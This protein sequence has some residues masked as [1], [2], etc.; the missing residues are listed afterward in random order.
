MED[1]LDLQLSFISRPENLIIEWGLGM[2]FAFG[3][4]IWIGHLVEKLSLILEMIS[5]VLFGA[6]GKQSC[7]IN[8]VCMNNC[9]L[10]TIRCN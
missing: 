9:I 7:L 4:K 2:N 6:L 3:L 1:L 8:Y 5:R 10:F